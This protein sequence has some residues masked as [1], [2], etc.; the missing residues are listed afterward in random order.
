MN[1]MTYQPDLNCATMTV[2]TSAG[3]TPNVSSDWRRQLPT[4][5]DKG[6]TLRE[7]EMQD[8]PALVTMITTEEV[9]RFVSPPPATIEGFERLIAWAKNER[10][11]GKHAFFGVV[12]AGMSNVVGLFQLRSLEPGFGTAEWGFMMSSAFWGTGL[13][14]DSA[15]LVLDF[16]FET[17]DVH[18]LEARAAVA[19]GRGNGAL[20]KLGAV[21]EGILRRAFLKNGRYID[22]MLWSILAEDWRQAKSQW[23]SPIV[24]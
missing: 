14:S 22:Q 15:R 2:G 8:A 6:V 5:S 16:A 20:R 9:Q 18:R 1:R 10:Q 24:H 13:F 21:Q 19:N 7:L 3:S 23:R 12:P 17:L 4:L 11:H